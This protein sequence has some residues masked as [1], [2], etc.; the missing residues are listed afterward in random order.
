MKKTFRLFILSSGLLLASPSAPLA[1][2]QGA[3]QRIEI[4]AEKFTF[5][6]GE[7]PVKVG[8]PVVLVL[9]SVDVGHGLRIRDVGVDI[10]VK[11]GETAEATFTPTKTGDFDGHCSVYCGPGHG[12]MVFKLHVVA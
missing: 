1:R 7:I 12:S 8:Q 11:A 9:T 2:A 6:P 4:T 3:P 5:K 10:K